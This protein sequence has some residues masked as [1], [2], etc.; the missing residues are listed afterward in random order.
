VRFEPFWKRTIFREQLRL[1]EQS[2]GIDRQPTSFD[3]NLPVMN[4]TVIKGNKTKR[5]AIAYL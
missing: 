4:R 5:K 1:A 3:A 2:P